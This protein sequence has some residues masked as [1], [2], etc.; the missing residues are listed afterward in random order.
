MKIGRVY[1]ARAAN[2]GIVLAIAFA[3]GFVLQESELLGVSPTL[4]GNLPL[5]AIAAG[6]AQAEYTAGTIRG[7]TVVFLP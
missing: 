2:V 1:R 6:N 3:S 5:E 7:E 4:P